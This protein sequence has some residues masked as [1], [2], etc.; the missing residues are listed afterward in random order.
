MQKNPFERGCCSRACVSM[1]L[2]HCI[3]VYTSFLMQL[4]M[5]EKI[6][7]VF[8]FFRKVGNGQ[9]AN[10]SILRQSPWVFLS[11]LVR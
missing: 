8:F 10:F 11:A 4:E 2:K 6:Y 7:S 1:S 9:K 5:K 3:K